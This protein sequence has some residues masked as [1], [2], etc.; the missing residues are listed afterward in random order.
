LYLFLDTSS[1]NNNTMTVVAYSA[2]VESGKWKMLWMKKTA[3]VAI[4]K[5]TLVEMGAGYFLQATTTAGATNTPLLGIYVGPTITSASADYASNTTYPVLVPAEPLAQAR[6]VVGT[7][8]LAATDVG[9]SFDIDSDAEVTVSTSSNEPVT[10][11]K[12]LSATEGLF[13]L[14]NLSSPAA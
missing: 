11:T 13:V 3:S 2:K 10:C 1:L 7:G 4:V 9:L 14:T 8:S 6:L 12:Y 5:H